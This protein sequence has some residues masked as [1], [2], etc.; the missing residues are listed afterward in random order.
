[1]NHTDSIHQ[2]HKVHLKKIKKNTVKKIF[3]KQRAK[4]NI[5]NQNT[6]QIRQ[7]TF[8][9]GFNMSFLAPNIKIST[10]KTTNGI[11]R[12]KKKSITVQIKR[13]L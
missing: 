7:K 8:W 5:G 13:P 10:A 11:R 9:R 2:L 6:K 4:I 12:K 3:K 1:M